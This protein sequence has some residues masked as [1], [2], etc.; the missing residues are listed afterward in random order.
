ML[1]FC[2]LFFSECINAKMARV[3]LYR[4]K[5]AARIQKRYRPMI[6]YKMWRRNIPAS[7]V[8]KRAPTHSH[9]HSFL[10]NYPASLLLVIE[11]ICYTVKIN[12]NRAIFSLLRFFRRFLPKGTS[13]HRIFWELR[14][15]AFF[16]CF[17]CAVSFYLF[18][19]TEGVLQQISHPFEGAFN[20]NTL[21]NFDHFIGFFSLYFIVFFFSFCSYFHSFHLVAILS[22][23]HHYSHPC[24]CFS[25]VRSFVG[26]LVGSFIFR[27]ILERL[28]TSSAE[29]RSII[30][31]S[32]VARSFLP[33]LNSHLLHSI[34]S[35][36][37]LIV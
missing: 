16:S 6:D 14:C 12:N 29:V 10:V 26:W 31:P 33:V 24:Y 18:T 21:V 27:L 13:V 2:V 15:W 36:F 23:R 7:H 37:F 17:G 19:Q 1:S 9:T 30:P 3:Q 20:A 4:N 32:I 28:K 11:T 35:L 34:R 5:K 8:R 22:A 25:F